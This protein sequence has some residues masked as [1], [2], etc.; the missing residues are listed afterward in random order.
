[1]VMGV[2]LL[3]VSATVVL[4]KGK[5][6]DVLDTVSNDVTPVPDGDVVEITVSANPVEVFEL[7]RVADETVNVAS[8]VR[9][10]LGE[11]ESPVL[12]KL[13]DVAVRLAE[14]VF[15]MTW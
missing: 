11:V 10:S 1:M 5:G 7:D 14:L 6:I 12:V 8:D 3:A 4:L 9:D 15:T 2:D 13:P